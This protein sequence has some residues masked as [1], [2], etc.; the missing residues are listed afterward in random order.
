MLFLA[1]VDN[2]DN[3]AYHSAIPS[4]C[5]P[6]PAPTIATRLRSAPK[7]VPERF[8]RWP[9]P[10]HPLAAAYLDSLAGKPPGTLDAYGRALRHFLAWLQERPGSPRTFDPATF[11]RTAVQVYF[12]DLE[13]QG[14]SVS[15]WA[16]RKAALNY[17]F[18]D[19]DPD[20]DEVSDWARRKAALNGF[21]RW[22]IE[23]QGLL[24][25]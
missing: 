24:Q 17:R 10:S 16:R 18:P 13:E 14:L 11:T 1:R 7:L 6:R 19:G 25:R 5:D 23:E 21:A 3:P 9:S 4:C 12:A 22:L 20:T 8:C 15:D 2:I